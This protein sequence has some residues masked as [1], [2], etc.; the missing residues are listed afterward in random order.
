MQCELKLGRREKPLSRCDLFS[1]FQMT[2]QCK[3]IYTHTPA[4]TDFQVWGQTD[5]GFQKEW[6]LSLMSPGWTARTEM[7][8]RLIGCVGHTLTTK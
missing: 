3:R 8:P 5:W 4:R 2:K 7:C 1:L 6:T